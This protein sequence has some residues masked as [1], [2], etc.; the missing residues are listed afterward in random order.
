MLGLN[1]PISSPM[2]IRMFGLRPAVPEVVACCACAGAGADSDTPAAASAVLA[3][4]RSRRLSPCRVSVTDGFFVSSAMRVSSI[5]R[6]FGPSACTLETTFRARKYVMVN[7]GGVYRNV[8]ERQYG[9][10]IRLPH[11]IA[12]PRSQAYPAFCR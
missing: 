9:H 3:T 8:Q 10:L 12:E 11:L 5:G 6:R 7:A 4:S 1:Q 2:I